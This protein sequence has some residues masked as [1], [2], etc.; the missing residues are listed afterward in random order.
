MHSFYTEILMD[1]EKEVTFRDF[2]LRCA[3]AFGALS[4]LQEVVLDPMPPEEDPYFQQRLDRTKERLTRLEGLLAEDISREAEAYNERQQE[5]WKAEVGRS[6]RDKRQCR[7]MLAEVE[8]WVP[9]TEDHVQLKDLMRDQIKT[10]LAMTRSSQP[11][12]ILSAS[13]WYTQE[14]SQ[15][16]NAVA[17]ATQ[18][19]QQEKDRVQKATEWILRLKESLSPPG[20][21]PDAT[22]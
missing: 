14:I 21:G 10:I 20:D 1:P 3:H 18:G 8:A 9:P 12:S 6:M 17:N 13:Q 15:A 11:P 7:K 5:Q 19:L 4:H 22:P 2:A 16:K